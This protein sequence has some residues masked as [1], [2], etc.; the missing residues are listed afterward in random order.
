MDLVRD[1]LF[2]TA[3]AESSVP[4]E[5]LVTEN[6]SMDLVAYHV[7]MMAEHD[8]IDRQIQRDMNGDVIWGEITALTW[9]GQDY[10]DAIENDDVWSK[11][12]ETIRNTVKHTTLGVIRDVAI[13]VTKSMIAAQTGLPLA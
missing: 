5:S 6:R 12:K 9:D 10:L 8:L 2:T 13:A 3:N 1:I 11:T 4:I 7:E